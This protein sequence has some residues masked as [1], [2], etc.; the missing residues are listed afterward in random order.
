MK[1]EMNHQVGKETSKEASP[2]PDI[3][4]FLVRSLRI[5]GVKINYYHICRT[6]LWLFSHGITMEH[7][8]QNVELGKLLHQQHYRRDKRDIQVGD[9]AIDFVRKGEVL[10]VHEVK[11]SRAVEEA[12]TAQMKYYLYYL[13]KLGL[14]AEGVLNYPKLRRTERVTL[15]EEDVPEIEK[16]MREIEALILGHMPPPQRRRICSKCAYLEYCFSGEPWEG[17]GTGKTRGKE[18]GR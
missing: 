16:E 8:H 18:A 4:D 7:K 12:H 5:T 15:T 13:R 9:I 17:E 11:K 1:K 3:P 10:E 2:E 6:K 14:R